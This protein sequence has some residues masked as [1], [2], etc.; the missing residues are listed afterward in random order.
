MHDFNIVV[1]KNTPLYNLLTELN[2][3]FDIEINTHIIDKNDLI[4]FVK[5]NPKT[6]IISSEN[7]NDNL[8]YF[9]INKPTRIN[10]LIE[11]ININL[12]KYK[13]KDQSDL[14]IKKYHLDINSRL[15]IKDNKRLKLTEKEVDLIIY[16]NNSNFEKSTQSLQKDIWK[17]SVDL[18]THTVE[19]HIYRLRKKISEKFNDVDFIINNKKGYKLAN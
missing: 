11:K 19:T 6:V 3:F 18:E 15:L 17:H 12:S 2:P 9:I 4:S 7:L 8:N 10:S 1:Y 16:L 13:F 14:I 5:R